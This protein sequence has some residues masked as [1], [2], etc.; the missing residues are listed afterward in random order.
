MLLGRIPFDFMQARFE[1]AY[2]EAAKIAYIASMVEVNFCILTGHYCLTS[3]WSLGANIC[4]W[5]RMLKIFLLA[6]SYIWDVQVT[7]KIS[8]RLIQLILILVFETC[9]PKL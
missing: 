9:Y 1:T 7:Q 3:G 2:R 5:L 6:F 4:K 8:D